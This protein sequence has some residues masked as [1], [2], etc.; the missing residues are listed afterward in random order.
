MDHK[1]KIL[2]QQKV[3]LTKNKQKKVIIGTENQNRMNKIQANAMHR[4]VQCVIIS[5][6]NNIIKLLLKGIK[7]IKEPKVQICPPRRQ[8]II[9]P[10]IQVCTQEIIVLLMKFTHNKKK[11]RWLLLVL[12]M[13]ENH[14]KQ[15]LVIREW[16]R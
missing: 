2:I 5:L 4:L 13:K 1:L 12:T 16:I 10:T 15:K 6:K 7:D 8:E 14:F 11:Q 3:L 9:V